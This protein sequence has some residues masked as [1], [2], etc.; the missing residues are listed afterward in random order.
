VHRHRRVAAGDHRL[1]DPE[2][3]DYQR[4]AIDEQCEVLS[5]VGDIALDEGR[6]AVHAHIVLGRRDLSAVGGHLFGGRVWPTFEIVVTETPV[7]LRKRM[8]PAVGLPLIDLTA[9]GGS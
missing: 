4:S 1:V 9:S 3:R 8:D 2:R 5:L 7:A 6:P